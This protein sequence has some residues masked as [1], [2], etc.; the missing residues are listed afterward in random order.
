MIFNITCLG[1]N[2]DCADIVDFFERIWGHVLDNLK[3]VLENK[4]ET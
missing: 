1:S 2:Q 4:P 3:V